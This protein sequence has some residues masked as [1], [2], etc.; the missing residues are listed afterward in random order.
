[1]RCGDIGELIGYELKRKCAE[2]ANSGVA[3]RAIYEN[4]FLT[5]HDGMGFE[6]FRHKIRDW[7]KKKWADDRTLEVANLD[8]KFTPYAAT[9][10]VN[11]NG[12]I[13]QAWVKQKSDDDK[14][15]DFENLE[16]RFEALER[17]YAPF[18]VLP[19]TQTGTMMAEVNI[20]DLHL[21]KLCWRGDTGNNFD[22]KIA[23]DV[24]QQL[25][26]DIYNR[27]KDLPL[28]YILFPI[29]NDFF[30]SDN[31]EKTTTAGTPQDTDVRWQ[32]LQEVGEEILIAG[33]D[34]LKK[35]APVKATYVPAN[36]DEVTAFSVSRTLRAWFR[37]DERVEIDTTPMA[38][39]YTNYG[40]TLI[41][42]THGD[43]E[44]GKKGDYYKPS[45]L[46]ALPSIEAR[47]LWG[48][49]Q[50]CEVHAAHLHG[51][52]AIN[53]MNGVIV[54]R[55]SS[56]TATD[57]WHYRSGFVGNVRKAQTFLYDK[58]YGLV[59]TINTPVIR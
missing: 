54:R 43:K 31:P 56:P 14:G 9:V 8:W 18:E 12:T 22:Y 41:C 34:V 55:V 45:T 24:F 25:I 59:D 50:Y 39:K 35:L 42:F 40:N 48:Q 11:G 16:R 3:Y 10:Q 44:N 4:T 5:E 21:G 2:L 52:H 36:H 37:N 33:I 46:A 51:E 49:T 23:R 53:E 26:S 58:E 1:M 28:E 32:K 17:T 15:Y 7:R 19:A 38:R 30:N 13:T 57:T 29:G 27:L 20:A 6:T 47:E